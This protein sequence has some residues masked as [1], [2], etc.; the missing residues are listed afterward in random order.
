MLKNVFLAREYK[1]QIVPEEKLPL[2]LDTLKNC[3]SKLF[4]LEMDLDIDIVMLI[5]QIQ[6][7]VIS[8][9]SNWKTFG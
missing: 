3:L 1:I 8:W 9:T 6:T 4:P 7:Q 5:G 2:S